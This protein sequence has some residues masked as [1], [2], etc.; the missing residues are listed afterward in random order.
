MLLIFLVLFEKESLLLQIVIL[1]EFY[2]RL[3]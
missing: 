3:Q 1:G 2:P